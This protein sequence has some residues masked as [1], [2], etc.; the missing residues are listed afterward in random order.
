M[1]NNCKPVD[2]EHILRQKN[3][4]MRSLRVVKYLEYPFILPD[5]PV[6]KIGRAHV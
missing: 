4:R 3:D 6:D 5:S 1:K 2:K